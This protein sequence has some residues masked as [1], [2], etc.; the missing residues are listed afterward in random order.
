VL[1]HLTDPEAFLTGIAARAP[2]G[3]LLFEATATHDATTPLHL[4]ENRGWHPGRA[5]ESQGWRWSTRPS[6]CGSGSG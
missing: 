6:G 4:A 2:V 3:C 1:E 5:L